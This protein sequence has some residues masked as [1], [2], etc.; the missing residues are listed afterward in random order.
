IIDENCNIPD[1]TSMPMPDLVGITAFTS[2]ANR[3]YK[4]AS[5]FRNR[6]VPV[7]MGGIHATMCSEETIKKVDAVVKGEGESV[8]AQILEDVQHK[9]LKQIYTGSFTKMDNIPL[10]RHDLLSNSYYFGSIQTTRGCPL[11]CHFC[12]VSTF[13]G[14]TYR[15]RP[16]EKIIQELKLIKE[17]YILIV[18]DNLI[19]INKKHIE[20]A[21]NLFRAIIKSNIRKKWIG[22]VTINFADDDELLKLAAKSGCTGVYIG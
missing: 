10:P 12:S 9:S 3:A 2:Q 16:I 21:K 15:Y 18:D 22:Q 4:I 6:G 11:N 1:Y 7:V 13:N 14:M 17:K 19:G 20:R 8:W 5:K